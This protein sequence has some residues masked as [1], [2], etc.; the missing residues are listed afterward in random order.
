MKAFALLL[1]FM[2][3]LLGA[4]S[5]APITVTAARLAGETPSNL[6]PEFHVFCGNPAEISL[7]VEAPLGSSIS[8][9]A[10]SFQVTSGISAPLGRALPVAEALDFK[11]QTHRVIAAS[12]PV[13]DVER[14]TELRLRIKDLASPAK[15]VAELRLY[16]YPRD[17]LQ[18]FKS[19]FAVEGAEPALSVFGPAKAIREFLEAQKIP[20]NDCGQEPPDEFRSGAIYL[21]ESKTEPLATR[22]ARSDAARLVYFSQDP[23]LLPGTYRTRTGQQMVTKISLPILAN[24]LTNP[25][26]QETLTQI[27]LETKN[28]TSR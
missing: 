5:P 22:L 26:S 25:L 1:T 19:A 9:V 28:V 4:E 15:S 12:F 14:R 11:T 21:G 24:L 23:G 10:D 7:E 3:T 13:P 27:L 20:F 2:T 18:G 6:L 16:V 17:L 8:L